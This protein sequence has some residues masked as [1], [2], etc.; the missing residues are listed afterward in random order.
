[1]RIDIRGFFCRSQGKKERVFDGGDL[2]FGYFLISNG[3]GLKILIFDVEGLGLVVSEKKM[4][5]WKRN[6]GFVFLM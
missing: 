3:V 1:M 4:M 2:G 5:E 6:P